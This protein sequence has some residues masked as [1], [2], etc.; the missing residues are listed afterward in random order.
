MRGR[1]PLP[2]L[3]AI[4]LVYLAGLAWLDRDHQVLQRLSTLGGVLLVALVPLSANYVIRYQRWRGLL[5][6]RGHAF[7]WCTGLAAYLAGFAFT[8]SPGKAG[9]LVR[10]RYFA[11]DGVPAAHTVAAF[12]FERALVVLVLL[13]FAL[14]VATEVCGFDMVLWAALAFVCALLAVSRNRR[15]LR[16]LSGLV[17]R[18]PGRW[19]R[20]V[21][22]VSVDGMA[23]LAS[24]VRTPVLAGGLLLG[25]VA[26]A[27]NTLVFV[28]L[29][30]ALS[31]ELPP[32]ALAGIYPL[33][34]LVGALSFVPGGIGTTELAIVLLLRRYGIADA[35]AIAVAIGARIATLWFA[36][37]VGLT[38]MGIAEARIARTRRGPGTGPEPGRQDG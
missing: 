10:A 19:L 6:A 12:V 20:I 30:M 5:M 11:H 26:W 38:A 21:V 2:W 7:G 32:H 31:L 25:L 37:L 28:A 34:M 4:T 3:V 18:L 9:E 17:P 23:A 24:H 27:L 33:A 16:A 13:A 29:C 8:A 15:A 35:D 14:L 22:A 36:V 1:G